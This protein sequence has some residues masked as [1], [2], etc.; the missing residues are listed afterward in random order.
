MGW[1]PG[2]SHSDSPSDRRLFVALAVVAIVVGALAV[3]P[4]AEWLTETAAGWSEGQ[5]LLV[6]V[7]DSDVGEGPQADVRGEE[8]RADAILVV[9]W[10]P[11]CDRLEVVSIPR[12]VRVGGPEPLAVVFGTGGPGAVESALE[13]AFGLDMFATVTLDVADVADLT[14][15]VGPLSIE[16]PLPARDRRSGFVGGPGTV[17]LDASTSIAFLRSRQWEELR[18]GAW[19]PA[20]DGERGRIERQ[21]AYLASLVEAIGELPARQRLWLLARTTL[22][23]DLAIDRLRPLVGFAAGV[24]GEH[25]LAA[26][27][28]PVEQ[29]SSDSDRRSPFA[30][31]RL[32]ALQ[33][34]VP[35]ADAE[36]VFER[37]PCSGK[38][39]AG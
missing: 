19:Q 37:T 27:T 30:P 32:G 29:A 14:R 35:R 5:A 38:E 6:V 31:D 10:W 1:A 39:A 26:A 7:D 36:R 20:D 13:R 15:D 33:R 9:R 3:P 16:L 24:G 4:S 21:Q 28:L 17:V 22:R 34:V 25:V 12:D 8:P 2:R 18:D 11:D 23:S